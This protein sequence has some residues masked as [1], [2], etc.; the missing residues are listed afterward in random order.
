MHIKSHPSWKTFRGRLRFGNLC[1]IYTYKTKVRY[2]LPYTY[3]RVYTAYCI[4]VCVCVCTAEDAGE[5]N[6]R[7]RFSLSLPAPRTTLFIYVYVHIRTYVRNK[8]LYY[9]LRMRTPR[10]TS[11][12]VLY[13]RERKPIT[14]RYIGKRSRDTRAPT[15]HITTDFPRRRWLRLVEDDGH[16]VEEV[17]RGC[18]PPVRAFI[19]YLRTAQSLL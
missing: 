16:L 17:L 2:T 11:P 15:P 3:T 8:T 14:P 4:R 12:A 6:L 7:I 19:I 1:I 9:S 10:R 5:R 13:P 18:H